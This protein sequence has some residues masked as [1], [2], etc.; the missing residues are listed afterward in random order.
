MSLADA[1]A[2]SDDRFRAEVMHST[3]GHL[4]AP[5]GPVFHGTVVLA[6]SEYAYVGAVP[7]LVR[8]EGVEDSPWFHE[9]LCYYIQQR[10]GRRPPGVY[11]WTGTYRVMK[12]G[13]GRFSGTV[14]RMVAS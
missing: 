5:T 11:V 14:K 3:W 9:E 7:V 12:N 4:R 10:A 8:I 1:F 13:R 6:H 2:A